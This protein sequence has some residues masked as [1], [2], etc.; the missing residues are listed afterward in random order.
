[1]PVRPNFLA[2]IIG[3]DNGVNRIQRQAREVGEL[4]FQV[5]LLARREDEQLAPGI[6]RIKAKQPGE[7]G[8]IERIAANE[9]AAQL[10]VMNSTRTTNASKLA[11]TRD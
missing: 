5:H 4:E 10:A 3:K 9:D 7:V 2:E 1:V 11:D 8:L 6:D